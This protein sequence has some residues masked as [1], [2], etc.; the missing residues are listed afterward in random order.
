[1][2]FIVP[3]VK[4]MTRYN[5]A[6]DLW[7]AGDKYEAVQI[8]SENPTNKD[9][10]DYIKNFYQ[11]T[12][13]RNKTS[14]NRTVGL[15]SD[16]TV[17]DTLSGH[18]VSD[19][20]DIVQIEASAYLIGLNS[21]GQVLIVQEDVW[22]DELIFSGYFS[23]WSNIDEITA[24]SV[25]FM[26]IRNGSVLMNG[27]NLSS[28]DLLKFT[29]IEA[30]SAGR[31]F[32]AG[33]KSDGTVVVTGA[34]YSSD[35]Q[36]VDDWTD[37]LEIS[38]QGNNTVG[39]KSNGTV[40]AAGQERNIKTM[41]LY[42][43]PCNVSTWKLFDNINDI[44][45]SP[46]QNQKVSNNTDE[47]TPISVLRYTLDE[48]GNAEITE[49]LY[50]SSVLKIP[51]EIEGHRVTAIRQQDFY[52]RDNL[53]SVTIPDSVTKIGREVFAYCENLTDIIISNSITE[54]DTEMFLNCT[55]LASVTVPNGV[56][57]IGNRAF[58]G[59][60]SLTNVIIPNSVI[61]ITE[62]AFEN[63]TSIESITIPKG[64]PEIEQHTFSGCTSLSS[65]IIPDSVSTIGMS[66]FSDC[67]S[68]KSIS[69]PDSVTEIGSG[70]FS[71]CTSLTSI[72]IPDSVIDMG[73]NTFS[74]CASLTSITIPN[75]VTEIRYTVFANCT[76]LSSVT[77]PDS[78]TSIG[79]RAFF[80]CTSLKNV[81]IPSSVVNNYYLAFDSG[82]QVN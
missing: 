76:S 14:V 8:L 82:T 43:G 79:S 62:E 51:G 77:I 3:E 74:G 56:T 17:L 61:E 38:A 23:G 66:A 5:K 12:D 2:R 16:G 36:V 26:G 52:G 46:E 19:W 30:V 35:K 7:D 81:E 13:E 32:I 60:D 50:Y 55:S 53:A 24:D 47:E 9:S 42:N 21:S 34:S 22:T 11:T 44:F 57:K 80:G 72:I 48:N 45:F 75:S 20:T 15:R 4:D 6:M 54:V 71:G 1:M 28:Y 73:Q 25:G 69:I 65:V 70:A 78:V 37:I 18:A 33:L 41:K 31:D 49:S 64:M 58:S 39:L 40:V 10:W 67:S 29:N 68:L 27:R 59:C 63:C